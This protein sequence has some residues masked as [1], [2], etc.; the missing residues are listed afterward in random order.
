M[1]IRDEIIE[2]KNADGQIVKFAMLDFVEHEGA[3]YCALE[4]TENADGIEI[5][6]TV[7]FKICDNAEE[8][9][10]DDVEESVINEEMEVVDD[11]DLLDDSYESS[12]S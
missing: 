10:K 11:E 5:G 9:E 3:L 8:W 2:L 7:F 12:S 4:S 6:D 1:D